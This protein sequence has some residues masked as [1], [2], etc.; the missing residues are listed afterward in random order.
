MIEIDH[1]GLQALAP[2]KGQEPL[3]QLA[4]AERSV[5]GDAGELLQALLVRLEP[6]LQ[7]FDIAA[8]HH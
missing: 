3:R 4:A 6:L 1:F 7:Q 8:D 2:G 5:E